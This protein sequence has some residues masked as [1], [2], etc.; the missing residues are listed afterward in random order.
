MLH[1]GHLPAVRVTIR[2][3]RLF[4]G[5]WAHKTFQVRRCGETIT[6]S[7]DAQGTAVVPILPEAGAWE[8]LADG[9]VLGQF[10]SQPADFQT[11]FTL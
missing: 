10:T 9:R 11:Q 2:L 1:N 4:G 3:N 7:T 5:F 8:V 6:L